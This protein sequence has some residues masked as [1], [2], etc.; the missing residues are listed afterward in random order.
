MTA[1]ERELARTSAEAA[2]H[3]GADVVIWIG[4]WEDDVGELKQLLA[5]IDAQVAP[6]SP[7]GTSPHTSL[8]RQSRRVHTN[9]TGRAVART[10]VRS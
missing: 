3:E 8:W 2:S 1:E 5:K 9:H 4:E 6:Q 7:G 10:P